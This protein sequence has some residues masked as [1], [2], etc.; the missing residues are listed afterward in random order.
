M[1]FSDA[2]EK[3]VGGRVL[4]RR[5]WM[6]FALNGG[7]GLFST[8]TRPM[9]RRCS[10]GNW[11]AFWTPSND[12]LFAI[13]W[14][15]VDCLIPDYAPARLPEAQSIIS[16]YPAA[17]VMEMCRAMTEID[18]SGGNAAAGTMDGTVS[19]RAARDH[20][21]DRGMIA[22]DGSLWSLTDVARAVLPDLQRFYFGN[23]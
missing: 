11:G 8:R 22:F 12:D 14:E 17:V 21:L 18:D 4:A 16:S 20:L 9:L 19:R 13:D 15:I 7:V 23:K 6:E 1:H 10:P 3:I 5:S 2:F